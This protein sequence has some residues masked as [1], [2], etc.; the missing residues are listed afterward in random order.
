MPKIRIPA[1]WQPHTGGEAIVEV[2][3]ETVGAALENLVSQYPDLRG[4]MFDNGELRTGTS[5]SV[6]VLLGKYDF[7]ELDGPQTD[8]G[9]S[10]T[11]LVL[12]TWPAAMSGPQGG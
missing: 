1:P 7:R 2:D 6:N 3:G 4:E 10:D 12:R 9:P 5:E 11:L 8:V